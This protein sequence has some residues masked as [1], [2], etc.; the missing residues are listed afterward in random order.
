MI[1]GKKL[2][3]AG[4][5]HLGVSYSK[6]DCQAFTE[7]CLRDCGLETNLAGSNAWYREVLAHG[8]VMTPEECVKQLGT[9]P[10]GAFLFILAQDGKEPEKYR[11]DGLGN[12]RHIGIVT[13]QGE[14]AIHSSASRGCVAESRFR[15]K[16]IPGGW[17]RVGLWDRVSYNYGAS[18]GTGQQPAAGESVSADRRAGMPGPGS[19]TERSPEPLTEYARVCSE[20]GKPVNTR[21]GPGKHHGL[22][23]AGKLPVGTRVEI[24]KRQGE[25]T[26][27]R[28][29]DSRNAVWYCWMMDRFLEPLKDP[30]DMPVPEGIF[31][32][33]VIPHLTEE[34]AEK[35]TVLYPESRKE[36]EQKSQGI[37]LTREPSGKDRTECLYQ[38]P[39]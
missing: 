24:L 27:I 22:S 21:K 31:Y 38:I 14:G 19:G 30:A 36:E 3:E 4:F 2:A 9:V 23:G 16:T 25:W 17:N 34:Q 35:L 12:A 8:A 18:A 28:V 29:A 20:N 6:M 39:E 7:Q 10:A 33:V 1:D 15:N 13:G 37:S 11:K 32:T 5:S 26:R